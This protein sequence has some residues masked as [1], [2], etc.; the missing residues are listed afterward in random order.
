MRHLTCIFMLA[1]VSVCIG[2]G[3]EE[4]IPGVVPVTGTVTHQG[5]P[6]EGAQIA[7]G[8]EGEGR[9]AAGKTDA[10]GRFQLTTLRMDD[11][12]LPGKYKVTIKK[13][14]VVGGMTAEETEEWFNTHPNAAMPPMPDIENSLPEKYS[15]AEESGLTA[16]VTKGGEN[17]FTFDLE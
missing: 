14:T 10:G 6:V 5:Q 16:E 2:C 4:G 12:A 3:G 8:P 7:F 11:G 13:I 9:A 17:D 15:K 1:G